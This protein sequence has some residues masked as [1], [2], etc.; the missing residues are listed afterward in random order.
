MC[1]RRL[2][3]VSDFMGNFRGTPKIWLPRESLVLLGSRG[4]I[5]SSPSPISLSVKVDRAS[6]IRSLGKIVPCCL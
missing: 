5:I 6:N 1:D 3:L 2:A 4:G